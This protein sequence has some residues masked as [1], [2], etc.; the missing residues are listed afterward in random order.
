MKIALAEAPVRLEKIGMRYADRVLDRG[1]HTAGDSDEPEHA[2]GPFTRYVPIAWHVLPRA[3]R[4]V[5]VCDRDVFAD[6]GCGK[7]RAVHQAALRPFR[8]V[9]G[10]EISPALAEVAREWIATRRRR[11]RC[12]D[13]EVIVCDAARFAI[14]DDLS[15]TFFHDPFHGE[16]LDIVLRNIIESLDRS[17]RRLWLIYNH[18]VHARQVLATGR[19]RL[20]RWQRGGLRDVRLNRVAIFESL[21][22]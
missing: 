9:I 18:P 19:F 20:V 11:Y 22:T 21:D 12:Q 2:A 1:L 15:V 4:F 16:T 3:F 7:G 5:G 17:P 6:F 8:R 10:I 13:V 14:P